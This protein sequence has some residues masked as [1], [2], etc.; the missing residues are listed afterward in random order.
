MKKSYLFGMFALAAMTMV[1]CSNDE[2]VEN[3]SQDNAIEFGTY[4]GRGVQARAQEL[5]NDNL[6]NFGVFASYTGGSVWTSTSP[7]NFMYNQK[8]ERTITPSE[9]GGE[10]T[11][12]EWEYSPL[13]YW[14]TTQGDQI[15]FFAYAPYSENAN[16]ITIIGDNTKTGAPEIKYTI[17]ANSLK[18]AEDFVADVLY[19]Q[20]KSAEVNPDDSERTVSFTLNHELT[21]LA[22]EAKLDKTV[23]EANNAKHQTQ[24]NIKEIEFGGASFPLEA[25]Y[26]FAT[27]NDVEKT[28]ENEAKVVRGTWNLENA[29][30][31][32]LNLGGLLNT[33]TLEVGT[34]KEAGIQ[35]KDDQPVSLFSGT[36]EDPEYLFLI[37][38]AGEEGL[39]TEE[40]VVTV[41]Y[42][43]V[44]AD[45]ALAGKHSCTHTEKK[46][47]LPAAALKQGV[48][49]KYVLT[50]YLNQIVLEASVADWD[51]TN[52]NINE[53]VDWNDTDVKVASN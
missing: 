8:V 31:G 47:N 49:Y 1:G 14:P 39:A 18:S 10:A 21:R 48:A 5:T 25:T 35:L 33:T 29:K 9:N 13:K 51:T 42:D 32:T 12:G 2:V 38:P 34:Y 16:C 20:T 15:S 17:N 45:D 41:K 6:T 27:E 22:F 19:N 24:V 7:F 30:Y 50:F 4:V 53:D 26:K 43:I 37:P 23:Y 52:G 36:E 28:D 44:T 11:V 40:V 46:I 3:F